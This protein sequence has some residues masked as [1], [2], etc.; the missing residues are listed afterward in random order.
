MLLKITCLKFVKEI[1]SKTTSQIL[2]FGFISFL[3]NNRV[4]VRDKYQTEYQPKRTLG[5]VIESWLTEIIY[6]IALLGIWKRNHTGH[7]FSP[8]MSF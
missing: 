1:E 6:K 7:T 2:F 4:F 8:V 5:E 3:N